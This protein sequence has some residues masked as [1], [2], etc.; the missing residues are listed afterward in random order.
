MYINLSR[1][2]LLLVVFICLFRSLGGIMFY[3]AENLH[4]VFPYANQEYLQILTENDDILNKFEINTPSR[5]SHFLAQVGHESAGFKYVRELGNRAYFQRYEGRADL[6]NNRPGD[7]YAYRGRGFIQLTGRAN[8]KR[9]GEYLGLDLVNNPELAADPQVALLI[10]AKYWSI[11][12]L[13]QFADR[14]DINTITKRINGGYNG[15]QDRKRYLQK[16]AK[17]KV[18]E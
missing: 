5:V 7:G 4:T 14:D 6:G 11:K 17:L 8:Y 3:S 10:A 12:N 16:M 1:Y 9:Y 2:I 18:T 15:L 13:N